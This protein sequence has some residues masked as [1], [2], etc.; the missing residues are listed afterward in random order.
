MIL[1]NTNGKLIA[2]TD[3]FNY[4]LI[5]EGTITCNSN[6]TSA[7]W[8]DTGEIPLV[9][10]KFT[11]LSGTVSRYISIQTLSLTGVTI[12]I[13]GTTHTNG[14]L[15]QITGSVDYRVYKT[16]KSIGD[17]SGQNWGMK[18]FNNAGEKTFDS[19]YKIPLITHALTVPAVGTPGTSFIPSSTVTLPS[20]LSSPIWLSVN[21]FG[22]VRGF[23]YNNSTVA[24]CYGAIETGNNQIVAT[25]GHQP[26][27]GPTNQVSSD[28]AKQV[29]LMQE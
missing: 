20:G 4:G 1:Y 21:S 17:V 2:N 24:L 25:F 28:S 29:F 9:F 16:F 11:N 7:T 5:A 12:G 18:I 15:S 10:F 26:A 13:F 14:R 8:S 27:G 22:G 6:W 3:D 23:Q 19:R